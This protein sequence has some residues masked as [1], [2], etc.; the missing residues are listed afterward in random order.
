MS[1]PTFLNT[2][3]FKMF[4][5][6]TKNFLNY[7][8]TLALY[9]KK[10]ILCGSG[11]L[12]KELI[13]S[14]TTF[15]S[16][17][18]RIYLTIETIFQQSYL[19]DRIILWLA[20]EQFPG[21]IEMLPN[22]L[23]KQI[24]R[25]VEIRFCDDLKSYKKFYYSMKENPKAI[26]ITIDDDVFYP[27]DTIENLVEMHKKY[28]NDIIAHSAQEIDDNFFL[29][30]SKWHSYHFNKINDMFAKCRILGL[31]GV[32]Y[33]PNSLYKD[34]FN[35]RLINKLC[36]W[37]DDLW[38][39]VMAYLNGTQIRRYEFRSNP[40]DVNGTQTFNL[41]RGGNLG[42]SVTHGLTNDDQWKALTDFYCDSLKNMINKKRNKQ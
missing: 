6:L 35:K 4:S 8:Y 12:D 2:L 1:N 7:L 25:G 26:V 22:T 28:P 41:S 37:A 40:L 10:N 31:S 23:K 14:L 34:V 32:L 24:N 11:T 29:L 5:F 19:P 21:G 18:N 16:R 17:I 9:R 42:L 13:V 36:P 27:L 38:L 39:T 3:S 15:P 30:P 33:P 20:K